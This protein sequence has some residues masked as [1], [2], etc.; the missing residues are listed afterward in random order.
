MQLT[1]RQ[2]EVASLYAAGLP[3]PEIIARLNVTASTVDNLMDR[4]KHRLGTRDRRELATLLPG[5]AVGTRKRTN[6]HGLSRGDA[7]RIAGGRFDGRAGVFV[8]IAN[9]YQAVVRIGGG[10][11]AVRLKYLQKVTA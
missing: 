7:L 9:S 5:C 2:Y 4:V 8:R 1:P 6:S 3:R 10:E 11:F